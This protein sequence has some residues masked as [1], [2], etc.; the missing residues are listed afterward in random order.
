MTQEAA[1]AALAAAVDAN[2]ARAGLRL[3]P[4]ERATVVIG[5]RRLQRAAALVRAWLDAHDQPR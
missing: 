1:E 2:A 5:A 4:S 3:T